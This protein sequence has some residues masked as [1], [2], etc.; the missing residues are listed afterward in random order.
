[1]RKMSGYKKRFSNDQRFCLTVVQSP[2]K[3]CPDRKEFCHGKCEKYAA[4]RAAC[5]AQ[6]EERKNEREY[7]EYLSATLDRFKRNGSF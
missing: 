3:D 6:A 2:C 1:M 4:F 5:D 7:N